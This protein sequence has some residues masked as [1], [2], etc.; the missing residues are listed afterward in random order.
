MEMVV[1]TVWLLAILKRARYIV[2]V[3]VFVFPIYKTKKPKEEKRR[4][5]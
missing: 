1:S 4:G 5:G 2:F 3:F